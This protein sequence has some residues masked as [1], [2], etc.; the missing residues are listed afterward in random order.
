MWMVPLQIHVDAALYSTDCYWTEMYVK[1]TFIVTFSGIFC[2][3][4][5][6]GLYGNVTY[7][8]IDGVRTNNA[9]Y[10]CEQGYAIAQSR[11]HMQLTCSPTGLWGVSDGILPNCSGKDFTTSCFLLR[12]HKT[13][14][15]NTNYIIIIW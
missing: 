9:T 11:D 4:L 6:E 14:Y 2:E 10:R 1:L 12:Y 3:P 5:S 7:S 8:V 13:I 15:T